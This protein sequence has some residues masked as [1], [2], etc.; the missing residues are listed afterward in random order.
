MSQRSNSSTPSAGGSLVLN[1]ASPVAIPQLGLGTYLSPPERTLA[2][3]LAALQT[4][5][6][7][8]IDT[9]QY[10]ANE[11]EVGQALAQS[12]LP[13]DQVF[14]TTKILTPGGSVDET[15]AACLESVQRIGGGHVDLF[16]IH[17]PSPG[18]DKCRDVW[19]ALERLHDEGKAKAIGVSNFGIQQI[20][21]L[22]GAGK[23]WPP[24]VNQIELHPWLQQKEIV[25][26]CHDKGIV[27][28]AYCPIARNQKA[29]N[30]QLLSIAD[31]YGVTPNQ[32]L[33]R[34]SL[35]K[36]WVCLPKSDSP[37]RIKLNAD[38]YGFSLDDKDMDL[39]NSLDEGPKGA[40]VMA[41]NNS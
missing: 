16:L 15:Y 1:T 39:L 17:S 41:V 40:L 8:H 12:G 35:Q 5:G 9:A 10:Y 6:Y 18:V 33:I 3:C 31:K 14:V 21:A 22:K 4:A 38:V 7:R 13:R 11:R 36:G 20:E 25:R 19:R 24:H 26:Y 28:E 27:I 37:D 30:K 23:V 2:S 34:W 29:D 32:V